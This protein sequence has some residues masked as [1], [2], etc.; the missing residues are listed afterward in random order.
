MCITGTLAVIGFILGIIF[1]P[2]AIGYFV[3]LITSDCDS[4]SICE[5]WIY[6]ILWIGLV[7]MIGFLL[8]LLYMVSTKIY[9]FFC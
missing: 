4:D 9:Y 3:D 8:F 6:G 1:I 5:R 2:Y 7:L